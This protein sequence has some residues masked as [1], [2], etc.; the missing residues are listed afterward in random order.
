MNFLVPILLLAL[1]PV[2]ARAEETAQTLRITDFSV[3]S[4]LVPGAQLSFTLEGTPKGRASVR[5]SGINRVIALTETSTGV[6]TGGYTIRTGDRLGAGDTV[7]A[8]LQQQR[9]STSKSFGAP[10]QAQTA[11]PTVNAAAQ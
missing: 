5:I 2:G 10:W 6:Y 1:A 3:N 8:T 4:R 7:R 11:A 9:R